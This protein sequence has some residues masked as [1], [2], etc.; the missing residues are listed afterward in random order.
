MTIKHLVQSALNAIY[1]PLPPIQE[2]QR[3]V[4]KFQSL[5]PM[6]EQYNASEIKLSNLN[7]GFSNLLKKSIL[8]EAVQGKLVPQDPT[9]EPASILLERIRAEKEQLIK[10]GKIKRDKHESVIFRRDNSHYEKLDGIERC[11]DDELPCWINWFTPLIRRKL[12]NIH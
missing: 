5:I 10:A 1:F 3:I 9:D 8:Q 6:L 11:I 2:Q 12:R 4:D 7:T